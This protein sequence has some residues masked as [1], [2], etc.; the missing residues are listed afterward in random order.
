MNFLRALRPA[1]VIVLPA[2]SGTASPV[3]AAVPVDVAATV[4]VA[5]TDRGSTL[6]DVLALD[7]VDVPPT[8]VDRPDVVMISVNPPFPFDVLKFDVVDAAD[9]S[10]PPEAS[11]PDAP[12]PD[13]QPTDANCP[14]GQRL[15]DGRCV[16]VGPLANACTVCGLPCCASATCFGGRCIVGCAPG[17][18]VCEVPP[19]SPTCEGGGVCVPLQTDARHCGRC[20]NVCPT[21]QVCRAGACAP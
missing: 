7:V 20:G 15:C 14:S 19:P 9:V 4:D 2:C 12:A 8:P 16:D 1:L 17:W 5:S 3:D 11:A 18:S 13:A 10:T 6:P 21:G